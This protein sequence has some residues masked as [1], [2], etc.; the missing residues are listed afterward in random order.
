MTSTQDEAF[1]EI[2]LS[3]KQLVFI[4]MAV[5]VIGV[6][7]FLMGVQ[8]GRG[9]LAARGV[10][11]TDPVAEASETEPPPPP[12]SAMK[13]ESATP[14][15]AGEKLSYAER[16]GSAE[17]AKEPLKPETAA[18][19]PEAPA[20][21]PEAV[22]A[23]A[24]PPVAPAPAATPSPASKTASAAPEAAIKTAEPAGP[25][26]AIQVAA[27]SEADEANAIVKRLAGKGYPA[28]VV[29]PANGAPTM[30]RVRVG[31]YKDRNEADTVAARLQKEEQFKPWIVR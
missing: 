24:P 2:Q 27:M 8:V 31:K 10:P 16:L 3:G 7:V 1:R 22:T 21:K 5:V 13:Q 6:G 11:G 26:F 20:P 30:Y 28:Y 9:V 15:T 14:T 25:G 4:A 29:T 19:P 18:P 17:P 12:T 23:S